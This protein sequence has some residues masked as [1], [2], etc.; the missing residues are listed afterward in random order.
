[1]KTAF[2]RSHYTLDFIQ[3]ILKLCLQQMAVIES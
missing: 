1:M 2:D 3:F